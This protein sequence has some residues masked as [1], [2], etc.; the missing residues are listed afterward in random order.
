MP[1]VAPTQL[2][3]MLGVGRQPNFPG[4]GQTTFAPLS[5]LMQSWS[6]RPDSHTG[7]RKSINTPRNS[8]TRDGN[9]NLTRLSPPCVRVWPT[10]LMQSITHPR[11]HPSPHTFALHSDFSDLQRGSTM[12][13]LGNQF[14]VH[15]MSCKA[16][17]QLKLCK[18]QF[19]SSQSE[20]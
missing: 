11:P 5:N 13:P 20:L 14:L 16:V 6:H 17:K 15:K 1:Q 7:R 8:Q 12:L 2:S 18:Q 10:R 9:G 3:V 19:R 4:G